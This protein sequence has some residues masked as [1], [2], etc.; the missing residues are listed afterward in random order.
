VIVGSL[1]TTDGTAATA[2]AGCLIVLN[3]WGQVVQTIS[4][5]GINGP[6]DMTVLDQGFE[7]VLFVTNV[8]NGTVAAAGGV[9]TNGTVLRVELATFG[10][11][12]PEVIGSKVIASGFGERTDPNA[13]VIGP[14]GVALGP[15]GTLYVADTL[16]NGIDAI[17]NAVTRTT[18]AGTGTTL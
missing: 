8:L 15:N 3:S 16:G 10:Y 1:P 9:V 11:G 18:D 6:W 13:L 7:A 5:G 2:K 12:K 17:P 14:T 4:G